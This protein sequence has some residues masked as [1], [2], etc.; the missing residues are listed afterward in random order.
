MR[1]D[2]LVRLHEQKRSESQ[3]HWKELQSDNIQSDALKNKFRMAF[4][5]YTEFLQ[6]DESRPQDNECKSD[7]QHRRSKSVV[8]RNVNKPIRNELRSKSTV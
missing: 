6:V 2:F 5:A 1:E 7:T 4:N 8:E 3:Q